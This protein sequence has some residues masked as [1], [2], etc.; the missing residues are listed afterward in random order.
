[1]VAQSSI[2]KKKSKATDILKKG[3]NI[4]KHMST[5][6][7]YNISFSPSLDEKLESEITQEIITCIASFS[8]TRRENA[9]LFRDEKGHTTPDICILVQ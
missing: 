2:S 4:S 9:F 7:N 5:Q 6:P 3:Q 1:M 8:D